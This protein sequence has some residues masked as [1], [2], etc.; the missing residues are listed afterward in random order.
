MASK[1]GSAIQLVLALSIFYLGYTIHS[2]TTKVGEIVE[3]Y[4]QVIEDIS[5]LSDNLQINEWLAIAD[6]LE[7]LVPNALKS[8]DDVTAAVNATNKTAASIDAKIPSIVEEVS[9]YRQ[10]VIPSVIDETKQYRTHVIPKV[11]VES[12]GYR[13]ETVPLVVAESQALRKEIPPILA[14]ADQ[15]VEKSQD[16]AQ[17][18]TQGAVK[19]VIMSPIDLIRDAGNEI[20]GRVAPTEE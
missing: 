19:G 4:P 5:A 1:I 7:Q 17:Q 6:T 12:E 2:M 20:K 16:I 3:T 18:A 11:L 15:I 10:S 14:K 8:I 9:L 13:L